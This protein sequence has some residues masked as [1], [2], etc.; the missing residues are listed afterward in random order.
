MTSPS[1]PSHRTGDAPRS[2]VSAGPGEGAPDS[3]ALGPKAQ[4]VLG[5]AA[6]ER[7]SDP[8]AGML[9]TPSG[10]PA[11]PRALPLWLLLVGREAVHRRWGIV[12]GAGLVWTALGGALVIDALDGATH[13]PDRWFGLL[14][15]FEALSSLVRGLVATGAARRLRLLKAALLLVVAVLTL[16]ASASSTFLLAMLFGTAFLFDGLSRIVLSHVLRFPGWRWSVAHGSLGAILG[17]LTLQPWPTWYAGTVG[18]SIGTFLVLSG[19]KV[20]VLG[21]RLRRPPEPLGASMPVRDSERGSDRGSDMVTV[22]VWT[23]TGTA[24]IPARQRLVH[25]YVVSVNGGGHIST[26]HAALE[27]AGSPGGSGD[28]LH[29]ESL[30]GAPLYVSH[31]PAVEIDRS[32]DNLRATLR[33]GPENEVPGRFLPSYRAEADDWCEATVTVTL[34]GVDGARLRAFWDAYRRDATYN[35]V[36]RNCSTGVANALDAAVEG[37]FGRDG[38]PWRRLARAALSPEFWAAALMR[39]GAGAMTWTPGLVLDYARALS[40]LIDPVSPVPALGWHGVRRR[41]RRNWRAETI[42]RKRGLAAAEPTAAK[43]A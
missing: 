29:D 9:A 18:F 17:L 37:S 36:G 8:V 3:A 40:A 31:Y 35:L 39:N 33:A 23:P 11:K 26:G 43:V 5:L 2:A 25:R 1:K 24:T 28:P 22:H 30:R 41:L 10:A 6:A 27:W 7:G 14:L 20:T 32:P 34:R 12:A 19:I 13:V 4:A 16:L 15:V 38:T 42:A 21:L